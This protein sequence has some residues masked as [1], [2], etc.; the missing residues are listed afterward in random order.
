MSN[1]TPTDL[2]KAD[3]SPVVIVQD[4]YSGCYSSGT[5]I[6]VA[7]A[8]TQCRLVVDAVTTRIG[9]FLH[10]SGAFGSDTDAMLFWSNPPS[11]LAVGATPGEALS[12]LEQGIK[13]PE[14]WGD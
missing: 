11:W 7:G 14:W 1:V 2:S 12:N 6:A 10:H 5:W 8:D 3:L 4:K 9:Y 13:P